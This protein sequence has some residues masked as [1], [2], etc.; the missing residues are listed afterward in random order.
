MKVDFEKNRNK[1]YY[2]ARSRLCTSHI[3]SGNQLCSLDNLESIQERI[4]SQKNASRISH[5]HLV[6]CKAIRVSEMQ[7]D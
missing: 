6:Q 2:L 5:I 4:A 1:D 7:S 3:F